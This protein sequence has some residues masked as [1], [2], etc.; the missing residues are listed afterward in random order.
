MRRAQPKSPGY[1]E[2]I[3]RVSRVSFLSRGFRTKVIAAEF[4]DANLTLV[5]VFEESYSFDKEIGL[6]AVELLGVKKSNAER[7]LAL[8]EGHLRAQYPKCRSCFRVGTPFEQIVREAENI[9]ANLIVMS[10]HSYG[11]PDRILHGSDAEGVLRR[12]PCPVLIAKEPNQTRIS[13]ILN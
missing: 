7:E 8:I 6:R 1:F 11:W 13:P 12:A 9:G 5:H 3:V 2:F 4:Q 10:C